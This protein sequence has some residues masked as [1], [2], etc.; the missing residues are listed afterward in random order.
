[1]SLFNT[2]LTKNW[3]R[4]NGNENEEEGTHLSLNWIFYV[5]FIFLCICI[6]NLF[7]MM[8]ITFY[9]VH[10]MNSMSSESIISSYSHDYLFR[11]SYENEMLDAWSLF[12]L[13]L[14]R[15]TF[16]LLLL[17]GVLWTGFPFSK[18]NC[19]LDSELVSNGAWEPFGLEREMA[20]DVSVPEALDH[21]MDLE[22]VQ[23]EGKYYM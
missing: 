6:N 2:R 1:M 13:V 10:F 14:V 15:Y 4:Y 18:V 21:I 12:V 23:K 22:Y 3:I 20:W 7:E 11:T 8:S 5:W 9:I 19:F 17:S 16:P